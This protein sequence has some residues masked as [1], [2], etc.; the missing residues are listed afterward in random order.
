MKSVI[1]KGEP[2][3]FG[4]PCLKKSRHGG[5]IVLFTDQNTG[6]VVHAGEVDAKQFPIGYFAR[7]WSEEVAYILCSDSVTLSND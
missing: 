7:N 6:F 4:Y 1:N 3:V 5:R 2:R